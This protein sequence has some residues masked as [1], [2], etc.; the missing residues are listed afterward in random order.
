MFWFWTIIESLIMKWRTEIMFL[1][2][3]GIFDSCS[4][5]PLKNTMY[6]PDWYVYLRCC[7]AE[8]YCDVYSWIPDTYND[9]LRVYTE[10]IIDGNDWLNQWDNILFQFI[11]ALFQSI[12]LNTVSIYQSTVSIQ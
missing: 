5:T 12:Q 2:I 4:I 11:K 7:I 8:I 9:N 6:R 10:R 1:Y 3:H